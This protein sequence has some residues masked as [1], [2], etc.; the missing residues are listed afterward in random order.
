LFVS[1]LETCRNLT[2]SA[3]SSDAIFV[4]LFWQFTG[5]WISGAQYRFLRANTDIW[6][7]IRIFVSALQLRCRA[8]YGSLGLIA[9]P[10]WK[11]SCNN[12]LLSHILLQYVDFCMSNNS[13]Q[14]VLVIT[15]ET[16]CK[17]Y[18]RRW[19]LNGNSY[20]ARRIYLS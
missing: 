15:L 7:K 16:V 9:G 8:W 12:L 20:S 1:S 5:S 11:M 3:A 2:S 19:H 14:S 10:I 18:P 6:R 17:L 4:Y 13:K